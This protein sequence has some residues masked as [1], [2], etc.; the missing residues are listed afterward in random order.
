MT[1]AVRTNSA[2]RPNLLRAPV[3]V[4][5]AI[6]PYHR[7]GKGLHANAHFDGYQLASE[8]GLVAQ[9]FS[10]GEVHIRGHHATASLHR[11]GPIRR[12]ARVSTRHRVERSRSAR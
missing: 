4:T 5:S 6:A 7:P 11:P 10:R 1:C 12:R 3:V 2:V 9:D 8:H